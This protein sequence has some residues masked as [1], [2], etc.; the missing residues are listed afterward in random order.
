MGVVRVVRTIMDSWY[1]PNANGGFL[2]AT[3]VVED[4]YLVS[5]STFHRLVLPNPIQRLGSRVFNHSIG[6]G[7]S[8]FTA[9]FLRF[10]YRHSLVT[11]P[12]SGLASIDK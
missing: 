5:D 2:A 3:T 7:P 9:W 1:V 11:F 4:S 8:Q 12:P 10:R 6:F